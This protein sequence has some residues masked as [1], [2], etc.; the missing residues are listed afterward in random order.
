MVALAFGLAASSLFPVLMLGIFYKRM[1]KEGAIAGMLTG[2][3]TTLIY[4]FLYK[5]W[6]FIPGTAMLPDNASGWIMG[7]SP[8]GFGTI[9]A[10]LNVTVALIVCKLTAPP[11]KEIQALVE[12]VRVPRAD[13]A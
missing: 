9:G 13:T 3:F 5:G 10:I 1:N 6:F 4:I 7:I 11:P 8:Q 2:L 12:S